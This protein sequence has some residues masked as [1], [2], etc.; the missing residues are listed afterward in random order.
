VHALSEYAPG[1]WSR[2]LEERL[3]V[4]YLENR[5]VKK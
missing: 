2:S 3:A 1:G 5:K 4:V